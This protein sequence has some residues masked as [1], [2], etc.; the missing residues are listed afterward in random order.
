MSNINLVQ[1][2]PLDSGNK[3]VTRNTV[4]DLVTRIVDR[5]QPEKVILFGSYANG[6]QTDNSDVDLLIIMATDKSEL[7][8]SV[9]IRQFIHPDFALDIIVRKPETIRQRLSW[10]DKFLKEIVLNGKV[11]YESSQYQMDQ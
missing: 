7:Q 9:A 8:Q 11:L 6:R 2:I 5:F 3:S 1:S 4:K 10:G